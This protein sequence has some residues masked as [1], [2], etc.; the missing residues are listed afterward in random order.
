VAA[1]LYDS[2]SGAAVAA[3]R[4]ARSA[5][6]GTAAILAQWAQL[7]SL[8]ASIETGAVVPSI[9]LHKLAA[10]GAPMRAPGV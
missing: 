9:I 2:A 4:L 1:R 10:A 8:T 6:A 7:M 3:R 5:P